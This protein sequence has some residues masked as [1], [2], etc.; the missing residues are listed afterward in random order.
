MR[1]VLMAAA[2]L[3]GLAGAAEAQGVA[4]QNIEL[5]ANVGGYCTIDGTATGAARSGTVLTAN[6][7]VASPGPVTLSGSNGQVICTSNAKIQL[8]TASGG[9]TGIT[10]PPSTEYT[11]KIHYTVTASYNGTTETLTTIDGMQSNF[12]TAGTDTQGGAQTNQPLTLTVTTLAT[13]AGKF[14]T[15]G[16]YSDTITVTLTP[17]H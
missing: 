8:T 14:L 2:V 3:A 13:P 17:Q 7:K 1:R 9:M 6:G 12:M 4:T 16:G 5:T 11:N 15:N 10:T